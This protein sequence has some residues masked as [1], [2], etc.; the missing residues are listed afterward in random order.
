MASA[1]KEIEMKFVASAD[2]ATANSELDTVLRDAPP[3]LMTS[4]YYDTEKGALRRAG[5]ALRVRRDGDRFVQTLKDAVDGALAR[6]EW[7]WRAPGPEPAPKRLRGTP[8]E[9]VLKTRSLKPQFV[10]EVRRRTAMAHEG[11]AEIE[12]S[13]D[14]AVAKARGREIAFVELELE[15][16]E[17]SEWGLYSLARR[18]TAGADLSLSFVSKAERGDTLARPPRS[19]ARKFNPPRLTPEMTAGEGF[20]HVARACL[21]QLCANAERLRLRPSPEVI[22]QLRVGVRRLRCALSSF[23]KIVTDARAPALKAELKWLTGELDAARN[24]DVLLHGDY[25]AAVVR[26]D[27]PDGLK[28]LGA[29]LRGAR[30]IAYARAASA[31]ESERY[32]RLMLELLIWVEA[33][34]WTT[35]EATARARGES[36]TR[37]AAKDLERRRRKIVRR[38]RRLRELEPEQRHKLRIEAKKLRYGADVFARLYDHEKRAR[39]FVDHLKSLQDALGDLNDIVVGERLVHETV[40]R[41]AA[42]HVAE[43]AFVAGRIS[44]AQASRVEPLIER[45]KS[46]LDAFGDAQPFWP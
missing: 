42:P 18:L 9:R 39:A 8:A 40:A 1:S 43:P 44:A 41:A 11:D 31:V 35:S 22:H 21:A 7:E 16:K 30:R 37:R 10:V 13:L 26:K 14:E 6:G 3:R 27:D 17:G 4:V 2:G 28:S 25:R 5:L 45:A 15:L 46:A 12:V 29:T 20:Q 36:I 24:L 23:K 34:P 32:R 33:G 38:G 19:F